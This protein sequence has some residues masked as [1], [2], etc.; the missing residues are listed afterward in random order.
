MSYKNW[1][2]K[3]RKEEDLDELKEERISGP[4][5]HYEERDPVGLNKQKLI[6][7]YR[8]NV[9]PMAG[10]KQFILH[11]IDTNGRKRDIYLSDNRQEI[12]DQLRKVIKDITSDPQYRTEVAERFKLRMYRISLKSGEEELKSETVS[13][14]SSNLESKIEEYFLSDVEY[15]MKK[16]NENGSYSETVGQ[17]K[18]SEIG[19][20]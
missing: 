9:E 6:I 13:K 5:M 12:E 19:P 1:E 17:E 4:I 16:I 18:R 14:D 2:R 7:R 20:K 11:H 15:V 10:E 8:D 3:E